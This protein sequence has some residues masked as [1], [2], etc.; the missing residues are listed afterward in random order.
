MVISMLLLPVLICCIFLYQLLF[1]F[2]FACFRG[3]LCTYLFVVFQIYCY[4]VY[5]M[6]CSM[7]V[8]FG[9]WLYISESF[10][11]IVHFDLALFGGK[12]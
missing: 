1:Q 5:L 11:R 7:Y 4:I 3:F 12:C 2:V 10:K 6:L 8:M 9:F